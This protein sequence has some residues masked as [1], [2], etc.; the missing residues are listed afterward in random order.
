[1]D[2][3]VTFQNINIRLAMKYIAICMT[4][5]E[6]ES[7]PLRD[8]LPRRITNAGVRPG[9]TSERGNYENWIF[10][11]VEYTVHKEKSMIAGG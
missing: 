1:M 2:K 11:D 6:Q 10:S 5:Q 7:S 9:N 4:D 3:E 8:I